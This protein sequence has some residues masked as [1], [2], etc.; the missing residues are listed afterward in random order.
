MRVPIRKGGEFTYISP[1]PNLTAEKF[2]KLKK[3]LEQLKRTERPVVIQEVKRLAELGD[4]SENAAYQMAKGRLRGI[5]QRIFELEDH[6]NHAVIIKLPRNKKQVQLGSR[7][8][9]NSNGCL[10][11]YTI[12]GSSE[13]NLDKNVISHNSPIGS[14]LMGKKVG[15]V[16][17]IKLSDNEVELAVV[18]IA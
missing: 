14:A 7:V 5:N 9:V 13:I 1:D 4:F 2:L 11:T 12:L 10:I 8:T 18:K 3:E 17:K 15:D 6:L 16:L